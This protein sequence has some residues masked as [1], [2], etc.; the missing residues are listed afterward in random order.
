M[1]NKQI[2]DRYLGKKN[3]Y[4]VLRES[5]T[6]S[7]KFYVLKNGQ[8]LHGSFDDLRK[9]AKKAEEEARKEG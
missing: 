9:A 8:R 2:V 6:W 7:T 4:E 3:M 1:D 5:S